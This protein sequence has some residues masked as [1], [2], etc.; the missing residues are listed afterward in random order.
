MLL[1]RSAV[2]TQFFTHITLH[3]TFSAAQHGSDASAIFRF[4]QER[5]G[6]YLDVILWMPAFYMKFIHLGGGKEFRTD[7][8][9]EPDLGDFLSVHCIGVAVQVVLAGE[10]G[11][12]E[13][14][15]QFVALE[16]V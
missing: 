4:V 5:L 1:Q 12:A 10:G 13:V 11:A 2:Q 14:A 16:H 15:E 9:F 8:A 7:F 3:V 6:S